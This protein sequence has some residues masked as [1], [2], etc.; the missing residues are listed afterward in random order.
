MGIFP[1][2]PNVF[3]IN[4]AWQRTEQQVFLESRQ[5]KGEKKTSTNFFLKTD[6]TVSFFQAP[7]TATLE[8]PAA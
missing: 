3:R 2:T 6:V 4:A 8:I 7:K 1:S 5:V